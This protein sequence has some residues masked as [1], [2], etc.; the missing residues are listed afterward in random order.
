FLHNQVRAMVGT[1]ELVGTGKWTKA[2]I[3]AAL[4]A[5]NRSAAGP[6]APPEGLYLASVAYPPDPLV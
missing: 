3:T 4:E 5:K 1:L 2:D 6:N